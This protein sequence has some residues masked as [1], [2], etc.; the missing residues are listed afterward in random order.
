MADFHVRADSVDVEQIMRQIRGR[1]R[2]KRGVDYTEEQIQELARVKLER[3][4]DPRGVRSDLLEQFRRAPLPDSPATYEFDDQTLFASDKPL[5]RFFRRLM[6]PFLKLLLNPNT[7]NHVLH[8]QAGVNRF[9]V[10][11]T[12]Q[13]S[14]RDVLFYEVIHN[15]V[16]EMTR[17][18][19]DV[20]NMKMRVESLSGRL[21]FAERRARALEAIVQYRPDTAGDDARGP[22]H[23][24]GGRRSEQR[25]TGGPEATESEGGAVDPVTGGESLRTRRRRRRRGRRSGQE[26]PESLVPGSSVP[27]SGALSGS[28]LSEGSEAEI[29]PGARPASGPPD[30]R[31]VHSRAVDSQTVDRP[32]ADQGTEDSGTPDRGT[33]DRGTQDQRTPDRGTEDQGTNEQGTPDR[34]SEG[35]ED[36]GTLDRGTRDSGTAEPARADRSSD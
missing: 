34:G 15:L 35:T 12:E 7:L 6:R 9:M 1:I 13:R 23:G 11:F 21:D 33:E 8:T 19:I 31:A 22:G 32:T 17:A 28:P 18:S 30:S 26:V 16:V 14:A 2:E 20:K 27:R 4:L 36:S 29:S 25:V 10:T 3:F 5:V 24:Q